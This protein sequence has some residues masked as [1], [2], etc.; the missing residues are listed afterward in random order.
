MFL[1]V[2]FSYLLQNK[3][4]CQTGGMCLCTLTMIVSDKKH[5]ILSGSTGNGL[6]RHSSWFSS[7]WHGMCSRKLLQWLNII[8]LQEGAIL[9][10]DLL[11][12]LELSSCC[13][14]AGTL[15]NTLVQSHVV[16]AGW[17]HSRSILQDATSLP[18][19]ALCTRY[20]LRTNSH[21]DGKHWDSRHL[22]ISIG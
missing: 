8:A 13:F 20:N 9:E 4:T 17:V 11:I 22:Y 6:S 14:L 1:V 5:M 2:H 10:L 21:L 3:R 7:T 16:L 18:A 12:L 19:Q 15:M